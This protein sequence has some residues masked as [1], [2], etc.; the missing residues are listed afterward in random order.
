M[1]FKDLKLRL[2]FLADLLRD[3]R[4]LFEALVENNVEPKLCSSGYVK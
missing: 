2:A 4:N 1:R 3:F